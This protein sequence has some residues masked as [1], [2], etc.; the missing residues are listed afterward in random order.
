LE[1]F[2]FQDLTVVWSQDEG[3]ERLFFTGRSNS[4]HPA[5]IMG[6]MWSQ[7]MAVA[8]SEQHGIELDLAK[9]EHFNSSTISTLVQ[10][11]NEAHHAGVKLVVRYDGSLKWQAMSF[12]ALQRAIAAFG[13]DGVKFVSQV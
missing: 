6:P 8:K 5:L 9:L 12:E 11:I 13:E 2:Q 7:V 3:L 10:F 1:R 4:R